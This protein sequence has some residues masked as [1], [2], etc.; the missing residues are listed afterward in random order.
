LGEA[1]T[2]MDYSALLSTGGRPSA[3]EN[4]SLNI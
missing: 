1:G 3:P 4:D 2:L